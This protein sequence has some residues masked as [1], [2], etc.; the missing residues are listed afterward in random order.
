VRL[1]QFVSSIFETDATVDVKTYGIMGLAN[2][3]STFNR[4]GEIVNLTAPALKIEPSFW[5]YD[6]PGT[7][8]KIYDGLLN[9]VKPERNWEDGLPHPESILTGDR[10][11]TYTPSG[12]KMIYAFRI[13]DQLGTCQQTATYKWGFSFLL[14]FIVLIFFLVWILGTYV[15]WLDAYLNSRLDIIKRDMGLYRAAL[16]ISTMI[17]SDLDILVDQLTPNYM[18]QKQIKGNKNARIG[19]QHPNDALPLKTRRMDFQ[20]WFKASGYSRWTPR[21]TLA[22]LLVAIIITPIL[23]LFYAQP[24]PIMSWDPTHLIWLMSL[25]GFLTLLNILILLILGRG[26]D[27]GL[28]HQ[29]CNS[30]ISHHPL[31]SFDEDHSPSA[32]RKCVSETSINGASNNESAVNYAAVG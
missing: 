1:S 3:T 10:L 6:N 9:A 31:R 15:L 5:T 22:V 7:T 14:L 21:F 11:P 24:S 23:L 16:D 13:M 30:D 12:T 17:Q 29:L 26:K 19:L 8:S 25:I 27:G 28:S 4:S 18:I 20:A 32:S 2:T